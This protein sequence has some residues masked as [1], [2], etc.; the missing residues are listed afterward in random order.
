MAILWMRDV[1][2]S[3]A[4]CELLLRIP[5]HLA[6]PAID[7]EIP[8]TFEIYLRISDPSGVEE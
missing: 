4:P 8:S 3:H 2:E 5:E 6:I 1:V 7:A